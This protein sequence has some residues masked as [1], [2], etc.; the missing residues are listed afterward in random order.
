MAIDRD[1]FFAELEGLTNAEAEARIPTW[2]PEQLA[3]AEEYFDRV[4]TAQRDQGARKAALVAVKA[5]RRAD[6]RT[7]AALTLAVGAWLA[8]TASG[9]MA[10]LAFTQ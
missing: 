4:G 7:T 9:L 8:A 6:M 3:L 10:Y 5:T 1:E 2:N